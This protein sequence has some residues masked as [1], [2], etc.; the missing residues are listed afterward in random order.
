M[1]VPNTE[2]QGNPCKFFQ[3]GSCPHKNDHID[4]GHQYKHIC[5]ICF[6]F[7]K[8]FSH[9]ASKCR[10]IKKSQKF[11]KNEVGTERF[12]SGSGKNNQSVGPHSS[13]CSDKKCFRTRI[14]TSS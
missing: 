14:V 13:V 4:G 3:K 11:S 8:R 9:Q 7:G 10:S 5:A 1:A 2:S 12:E 6:G